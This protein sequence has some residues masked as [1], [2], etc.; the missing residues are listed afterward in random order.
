MVDLA[1]DDR[2]LRAHNLS[3]AA[4]IGDTIYNFGELVRFSLLSL[5][6]VS[7]RASGY[8]AYASY[9]FFIGWNYPRMD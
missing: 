1:P 9:T 2:I 6:Y 7:L 5:V 8:I 4:L 3:V